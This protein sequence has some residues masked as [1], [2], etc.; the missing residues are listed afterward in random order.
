MQT[1]RAFTQIFTCVKAL[2]PRKGLF[3]AFALLVAV[4]LTAGFIAVPVG[5]LISVLVAVL[6]IAAIDILICILFKAHFF[7][8]RFY[9]YY[10]RE[11]QLYTLG[12]EKYCFF[13]KT[14][15]YGSYICY[16]SDK[17]III[18]IF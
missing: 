14:V 17:S 1:K 12:K 15:Y 6:I 18:I 11:K 4:T 3:A 9:R 5:I 16:N 13:K 8:P 2:L 10:L 7:S